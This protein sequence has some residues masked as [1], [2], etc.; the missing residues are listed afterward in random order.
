MMDAI[1]EP[2]ALQ[3]GLQ[4]LEVRGVVRDGEV[5]IDSLQQLTDAEV[6]TAKL[7]ESDVTPIKGGL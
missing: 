5:C 3:I 6:I 1:G 7:I 2:D 4:G